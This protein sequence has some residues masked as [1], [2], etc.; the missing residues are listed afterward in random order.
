MNSSLNCTVA[1]RSSGW[2]LGSSVRTESTLT[3]PAAYGLA[4]AAVDCF[5]NSQFLAK[6]GF[7]LLA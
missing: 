1:G 2:L 6:V 5:Y 3:L 4:G 7:S